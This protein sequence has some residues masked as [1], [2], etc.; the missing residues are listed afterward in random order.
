V[1]E[2]VNQNASHDDIF[3]AGRIWCLMTG[4]ARAAVVV[5]VTGVVLV[6]GIVGAYWHSNTQPS[7]PKGISADAVFLWAPYVGV[8]GPRRGWWLSCRQKLKGSI[9]CTLSEIDGA[10][11]YEGEF[12]PYQKGVI[13][14]SDVLKIDPIKSRE[15]GVWI[16][17]KN[18]PLVFL[19]NGEI[20]IPASKYDE[21]R[22]LLDSEKAPIHP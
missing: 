3:F 22:R 16:D 1:G 20:L 14:A 2:R 4:R 17:H 9:W 12:I 13:V 8:P 21:G 15:L 10:T 18:V 11:K 19:E 7:K 5:G 6:L